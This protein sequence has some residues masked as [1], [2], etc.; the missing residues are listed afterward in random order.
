MYKILLFLVLLTEPVFSQINSPIVFVSRNPA[1][2]GNIF[3]PQAGLL[4]GMGGFSRFKAPGGR[5]L[6]RE[7]NG[8]VITLL[9][10]IKIINGIRLIDVQQP[11]VSWDGLRIL[12][13][14]IENRDSNWRIYEITADGSSLRKITHTDRFINL[15][16]FGPAASKFVKYDDIDPVYLPNGKIIFASTRFPTLSQ[17]DGYP[18]TNL[19]IMDSTGQNMFR[20]TT[21]RNSAEKPTI[22][23]LGHIVYSRWLLNI[24]RPSNSAPNNI[25][26]I[27]SLALTNDI[28]NIWQNIQIRPDGDIMKI[29]SGD[30]RNRKSFFT[31]RSRV[32]Q[33]GTLFGVYVP[34]L[35]MSFTG[36]SPGI[37]Y[38][39]KGL[40]QYKHIIGVD[41][42]TSLYVNNPPSTGTY[43]PPYATD[44]LPLNNGNILLS[45]ATDPLTAD[46]GIYTC[47]INGSGLQQ[48]IN[49][50]GTLEL[51]AE[52][53]VAR[54]VPP[55]LPY[56]TTFDTNRVPPTSDPSTFYQG[57]L[58]RFD[59]LNIYT[60]APVDVPIDDAPKI[61]RKVKIQFFMNHQRQDPNGQDFPILF[62]EQPIELTGLLA[63]GES[64]ANVNL[65]E[66]LVDDSGKVLTNN[67][68]KFAHVS[69]MNFGINGSGA[70]C[71]GCHAGHTLIPLPNSIGEA[72]FTNYSTSAHVIESSVTGNYKG[73][74]AI[75][76]K[77]QNKNLN[78]NWISAG[79]QDQ[80]LELSW[81]LYMDVRELKLYN[82]L[83]NSENG[84]NINVNDCDVTFYKDGE[85]VNFI[86]STG[87]LKP[88]GKSVP[89]SPAVL[90]NKIKVR[91]KE[92]TGTVNG[93]N[94]A[95]LAEIET[96]AKISYANI[97]NVNNGTE[98]VGE[99]KLFQNYPNPFNPATKIDYYLP[100]SGHTSLRIYDITGKMIAALVE[101]KMEK[102]FNSIVFDA[103]SLPSGVYFYIL[104]SNDFVQ[105][106]KMVLLK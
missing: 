92:F 84:T 33:D 37:R 86:N 19:Y 10:S 105:S 18:A 2:N 88:D 44:P 69:G 20:I 54:P 45:Y 59:C 28:A 26:R 29:Y 22:D 70:K 17:I 21:E 23:P 46:F 65:F 36:G 72:Q 103:K 89:V 41:T 14:G 62:G 31:Y 16:Q 30:P 4:P 49:F 101:G 81:D 91:I 79:T 100:K 24:D 80:Y 94:V 53:L 56:L 61:N 73:K 87:V 63:S 38:F 82:I 8:N 99:Y 9:D 32:A 40:A 60:N 74:N 11:C 71:V 96:I 1:S 58:F 90:C 34:S 35:S 51:N 5:M 42:T 95:G 67:N 98:I 25:T 85:V 77:A 102:G 6:I 47:N 55:S 93:M 57:G 68:G 12:F 106:K 39:E 78:V 48:V 64:P 43:S 76:R 15:S 7:T 13:A 97:V 83:S 66:Q 27:D 104:K 75:D 50:P 3:F 52:L